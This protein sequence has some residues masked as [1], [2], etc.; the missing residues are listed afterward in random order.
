MKAQSKV[1]A[2]DRTTDQISLLDRLGLLLIA[3]SPFLAVPDGLA[4]NDAQHHFG[5]NM[6]NG[7]QN[8]VYQGFSSFP[9]LKN[10]KTSET[11]YEAQTSAVSD[12]F[13]KMICG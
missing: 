12:V 8:S 9:F 6:T 5:Q 7:E 4:A 13:M 1:A 11:A 10:V 2:A 3:A